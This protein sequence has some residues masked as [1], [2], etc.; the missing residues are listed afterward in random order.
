MAT[1]SDARTLPFAWYS[2]EEQLRRERARIFAR[3]WQYAARSSTS[4]SREVPHDR[5]R[6]R[7]VL[8]TRDGEGELRAFLNVCRHR[9]AVLMDG[10]GSRETIQCG[11]HAWTYGLDG[12]LRAAPRSDREPGF[13]TLASGSPRCR[14]TWGPFL[15]VNPDPGAPPLADRLGDLPDILAPAIDVHELLFHSRVEF[16]RER[17]LEDR[18]RELPRVLPLPDGPP[19][20][21]RRGLTCTPTGTCSS[22]RPTYAASSRQGE[23]TRRGE[24]A[25]SSICFTRTPGSTSSPAPPNLSIGPIV[26]TP[27]PDRALP[28]LLLRS[29]L[30]DDWFR[31]FFASTTRSGARTRRSSSRCI[32]GWPPECWSTGASCSG[33][34]R[35]AAFQ[36]LG[37]NR[38]GSELNSPPPPAFKTL[39][40]NISEASRCSRR[41]RDGGCR[42]GGGRDRPDERPTHHDP[43]KLVV[44][45]G[46]P[47]VNFANGKVRGSNYLNPKGY[48]VDLADRDRDG[49]RPEAV[50]R[51]HAVGQALR[52]RSQDVRHLLPGGDDHG[53]AEED[54]RLHDVVLRREPGRAALEE[55]GGAARASP[56]SRRCR[57]ARRPTRPASTGSSKAAPGQGAA[58]LPDDG[59]RVRRGPDRPVR[60]AH[61]RHADRRVG[62]EVAPAATAR[63]PARS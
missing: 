56:T 23:T 41:R 29:R 17:E 22:A 57:P 20:L 63:S 51:L 16:G 14:R 8:V 31:G 49:S 38:L 61:A 12:A 3:S 7:P 18:R 39:R 48:E 53:P 34:S 46:D 30:A 42:A 21:Q 60:R 44:G 45:F 55:G 19:R 33:L 50:V 9:G 58:D 26:P 62:E 47:A 52:A 6:R 24:G 54:D 1:A 59:R 35:L 5:R 43:G 28:G 36:G 4:A 2:D 25:A 37:T 40:R 11:Y 13:D 10:C 32:A 27:R 15:F